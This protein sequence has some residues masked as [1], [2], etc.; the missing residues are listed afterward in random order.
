MEILIYIYIYCILYVCLPVFKQR[1]QPGNLSSPK[2]PKA[3][4]FHHFTPVGFR[5]SWRRWHPTSRYWNKRR[6]PRDSWRLTCLSGIKERRGGSRFAQGVVS[7]PIRERVIGVKSEVKRYVKGMWNMIAVAVFRYLATWNLGFKHHF[8]CLIIFSLFIFHLPWC[9]S[10]FTEV[11]RQTDGKLV[12][13]SHRHR[14]DDNNRIERV[15]III[16]VPSIFPP[17][18][19]HFQTLLP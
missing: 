2:M 6:P 16:I 19:K 13:S 7:P 18:P 12:S 10:A 14:H 5:R 8:F 4:K 1:F 17:H 11:V 3:S 15:I 9:W